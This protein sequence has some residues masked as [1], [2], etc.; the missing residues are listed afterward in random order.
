M[1]ILSP[2][3]HG[4]LDYLVV[5]AFLIGPSLFAFSQTPKTLAYVLGV[6]HLFVTLLTAFPLGVVKLIPFTVHGVLEFLVALGLIALPWLAGFAA[7]DAPA[8]TFYVAAGIVVL[9][10]VAVTDYK[11]AER[12]MRARPAV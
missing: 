10:V 8:R 12:P 1:K 5:A 9:L 3:A 6:V 7:T 11:A 2:R 4:Y